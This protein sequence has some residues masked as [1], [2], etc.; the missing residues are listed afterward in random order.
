MKVTYLAGFFDGEGSIFST[1]GHNHPLKT[2]SIVQKNPLI[3]N[4]ISEF[5]R[6]KGINNRIRHRRKRKTSGEHYDLRIWRKTDVT[7]FCRLILPYVI[8]KHD[9]VESTLSLA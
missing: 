5:L 3:L 7:A 6:S 9:L 8:V 4:Q 2:V 1:F